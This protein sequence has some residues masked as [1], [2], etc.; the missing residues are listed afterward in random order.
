MIL[1]EAI[2]AAKDCKVTACEEAEGPQDILPIIKVDVKNQPSYIIP[3]IDEKQF[4]K[5]LQSAL[6]RWFKCRK[7]GNQTLKFD[8]ITV[9]TEGF[10]KK[11]SDPTNIK[12]GELQADYNANPMSDV[13]QCIM[14]N[15]FH[16]DC[17]T[18]L[19][20]ITYGY[21]DFGKVEFH[22]E[23]TYPHCDG[24]IVN[25]LQSFRAYCMFIDEMAALGDSFKPLSFHT[26][27]ENRIGSTNVAGK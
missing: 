3:L 26:W 16:W 21:D 5:S 4:D 25:V 1:N 18:E 17:S 23:N 10:S 2:L 24:N 14:I 12:R 27:L 11:T 7:S 22:S 20:I 13:N 9:I 15:T 8:S 19:A 6:S